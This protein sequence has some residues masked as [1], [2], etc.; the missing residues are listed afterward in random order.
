MLATSPVLLTNG[1]EHWASGWEQKKNTERGDRNVTDKSATLF[2]FY[3]GQNTTPL[4]AVMPPG[5]LMLSSLFNSDPFGLQSWTPVF[6]LI[7][8]SCK[9]LHFIICRWKLFRILNEKIILIDV[10]IS[11]YDVK[12]LRFPPLSLVGSYM[13]ASCF[14]HEQNYAN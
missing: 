1:D 9:M 11:I 4:P 12:K 13:K 3:Q 7:L 8:F 14:L 6:I 2:F 5:F 10:I